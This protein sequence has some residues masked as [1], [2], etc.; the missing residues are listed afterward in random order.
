MPSLKRHTSVATESALVVAE[1]RQIATDANPTPPRDT[2]LSCFI[3]VRAA[4]RC[5]DHVSTQRTTVA[6]SLASVE[7][8]FRA[9]NCRRL[10]DRLSRSTVAGLTGPVASP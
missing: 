1:P 9:P 2:P 7:R 3:L 6:A 4:P 5:G 10:A 8:T